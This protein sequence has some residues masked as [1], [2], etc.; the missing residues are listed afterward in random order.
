VFLGLLVR[1]VRPGFRGIKGLLVSLDTV[2]PRVPL[3]S[4]GIRV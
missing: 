2:D 3:V 1:L 4:L